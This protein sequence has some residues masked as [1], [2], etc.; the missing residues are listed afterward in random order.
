MENIIISQCFPVYHMQRSCRCISIENDK[1]LLFG[2]FHLT[3]YINRN[4]VGGREK[5]R[6]LNGEKEKEWK[7]VK[8]KKKWLGDIQR[9]YI[10]KFVI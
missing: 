9:Q 7:I 4:V 5:E 2:A 1:I 8:N 10:N 6:E 3:A